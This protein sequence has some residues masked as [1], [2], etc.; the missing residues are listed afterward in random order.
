MIWI[1]EDGEGPFVGGSVVSLG[2]P[3]EC[4]LTR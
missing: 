1:A 3:Q 2:G 4:S